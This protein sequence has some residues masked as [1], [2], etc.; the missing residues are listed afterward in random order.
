M[1]I[2]LVED[3]FDFQ[4]ILAEYLVMSGFNVFTANHGKDGLEVFRN[5]H[6]DICILDIMM[7]VM[8][9]FSLAEKLREMDPS[10]P[11]IFL[12]AKN[13]KEDK[14]RGLRL[15]ADDYITKPFEA[16]EL[17]LRINNILRR[18]STDSESI[19][20]NS[21]GKLKLNREELKLISDANEYQLTI[22][23]AELL[24]FL[25]LNKN[26][27]IQREKILNQLW[28]KS[29]Y[30]MGRSMDVFISRIRKYLQDD[31]DLSLETIRGVGYILRELS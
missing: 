12:T 5:N 9:G 3:E 2:L 14:H 23:E 21:I 20:V 6:I 4:K 24:S 18:T 19:S 1:N 29:D 13:Q 8:D 7:P 31:P 25:A 27:V 22:K 16:E 28:G 10:I 17:V 11:I 26:Q 15:G 30:F